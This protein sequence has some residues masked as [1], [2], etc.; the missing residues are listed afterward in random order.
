MIRVL[1][2]VAVLSF[3]VL[4]GCSSTSTNALGLPSPQHR[5]LPETKAIRNFCPAPEGPRELAKA[6]HPAHVLEPGD[7]LLVTV[8]DLDS[9]IRIPADQPV[10]PDGTIDLA[11]YGR[12]V[13][14]GMTIPAAEAEILRS[15]RMVEKDAAGIT[16]RLLT[17]VSK[18]Y[19]VLGEVNA[20]GVFPLTGRETALDAIMAAGGLNRQASEGKILLSRP[21]QPDG[22]R[23][24]LPICYPQIVQ[25]G[26]TTTNYQLQAGDRIYVSSRSLLENLF[27]ASAL[28]ACACATQ[29][30]P[31]GRC[32]GTTP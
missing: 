13:V 10:Q 17:R 7:A 31:C 30:M 2:P 14:A 26:D 15:V 20:P 16:V 24:V 29:Q 6:L 25:L 5:L 32:A 19:Y 1:A 27:P 21:T 9:P 23:V 3:V 4:T 12:P 8:A 28:P 18:V 11:K 22:C